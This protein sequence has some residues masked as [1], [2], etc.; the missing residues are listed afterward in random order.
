M[1]LRPCLRIRSKR[2]RNS[3]VLTVFGEMILI[4]RAIKIISKII[5]TGRPV[6]PHVEI[7]MIGITM[8]AI[9]TMNLSIKYF[10]EI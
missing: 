8:R 4:E 1:K 3:T 6:S 7:A 9:G 10:L 5:A 2:P